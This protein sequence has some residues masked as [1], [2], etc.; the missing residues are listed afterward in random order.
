LQVFAD[1]P[2]GEVEAAGNLALR[3]SR[4]VSESQNVFDLTHDKPV[5]WHIELSSLE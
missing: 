1:D 5:G 2:N 3:E 4:I